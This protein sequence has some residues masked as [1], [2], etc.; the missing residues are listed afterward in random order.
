MVL[1]DARCS[2]LDQVVILLF[3]ADAA[4]ISRKA[5]GLTTSIIASKLAVNVA[6]P[7][8]VIVPFAA[9]LKKMFLISLVRYNSIT[10]S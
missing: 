10:L 7:S 5:F 6:E 1:D 2:V 9:A 8:P 4:L 3:P